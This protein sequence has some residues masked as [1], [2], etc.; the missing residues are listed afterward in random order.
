MGFHSMPTEAGLYQIKVYDSGNDAYWCYK[1]NKANKTNTELPWV[2]KAT[3]DASSNNFKVSAF[4]L[5][6][7]LRFLAT[8]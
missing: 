1:T 4:V 2:E 3:L 8:D 7:L 5:E 6:P